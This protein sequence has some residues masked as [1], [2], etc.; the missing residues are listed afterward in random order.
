MSRFVKVFVDIILVC[1]II[2]GCVSC[3]N[4]NP[5]TES[6]PKE[7]KIQSMSTKDTAESTDVSND[8]ANASM[9]KYLKYIDRIEIRNGKC[10]FYDTVGDSSYAKVIFE[11]VTRFIYKTSKRKNY[12]EGTYS[13][14]DEYMGHYEHVILVYSKNHSLSKDDFTNMSE[15][16]IDYLIEK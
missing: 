8:T 11:G 3:Q 9:Q 6:T 14:L 10:L 13:K 1:V 5:K 2:I 15:W 4:A 7:T 16:G 12:Y